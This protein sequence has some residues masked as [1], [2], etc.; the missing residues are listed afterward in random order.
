MNLWSIV[1]AGG[2]GTRLS[3]LA[4]SPDGRSVP[5]QYCN[6]NGGPS[7]LHHAL[8]R[9]RAIAGVERTMVV[10]SADHRCWWSAELFD[11]PPEN[12]VVQP[13]NRGTACGLLLP[14]MQV[15]ARDPGATVVVFPSDHVVSDENT[16][17][18]AIAAATRHIRREPDRL[19]LLGLEPEGPDTGLGWIAPSSVVFPPVRG[20]VRFVEKP[21]RERAEELIREGALWNSFIFTMRAEAL[22]A[23]FEWAVPWVTRMFRYAHAETNGEDRSERVCRMYDRLPSVDFSRAVL[24]QAGRIMR[25]VAVPPCGWTDIGTPE[26][27]AHCAAESNREPMREGAPEVIAPP[28]VDLVE[29][30]RSYEARTVLA[31]VVAEAAE[32]HPGPGPLD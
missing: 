13:C 24:Q 4:V 31:G 27:I 30:L 21:D 17:F 32:K 19:V 28:P 7:L 5:K 18:G 12:V 22:F 23:L 11:H 25:V 9:G 29:A 6:V 1:L 8:G 16:L 2:K 20:V 10:V 15:L 3:E 14:L 26:G